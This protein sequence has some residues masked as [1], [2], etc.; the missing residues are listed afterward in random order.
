M[1]NSKEKKKGKMIPGNLTSTCVVFKKEAYLN[2][3]CVCVVKGGVGV[4]AHY[5]FLTIPRLI[6]HRVMFYAQ[7]HVLHDISLPPPISHHCITMLSCINI[8][9]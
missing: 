3:V 4:A 1:S 5:S 2:G 7:S 6:C 8:Y 9:V